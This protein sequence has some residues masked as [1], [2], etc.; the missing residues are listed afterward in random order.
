MSKER[1]KPVHFTSYY[2][3]FVKIHHF[4]LHVYPRPMLLHR[5]N[6]LWDSSRRGQ[7]KNKIAALVAAFP[8]AAAT[9]MTSVLISTASNRDRFS[10]LFVKFQLICDKR[11]QNSIF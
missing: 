9:S 6:L 3:V 11:E 2:R 4:S 8:A 10:R 1:K 7:R 5:I